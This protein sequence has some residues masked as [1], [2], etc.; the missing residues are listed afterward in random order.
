MCLHNFYWCHLLIH[1][2]IM[3][4][5]VKKRK[6]KK[7]RRKKEEGYTVKEKSPEGTH[8]KLKEALSRKPMPSEEEASM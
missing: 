2:L 5:C 3:I 7:K 4:T 1:V 6:E 8:S